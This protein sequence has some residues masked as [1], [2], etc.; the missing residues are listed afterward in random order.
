MSPQFLAGEVV[1]S[2]GQ[3]T[4]GPQVSEAGMQPGGGAGG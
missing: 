1:T 4:I 3:V 2:P